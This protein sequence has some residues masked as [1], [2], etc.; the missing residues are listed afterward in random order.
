MRIFG[1]GPTTCLVALVALIGAILLRSQPLGASQRLAIRPDDGVAI[2][3]TWYE[4]PSRPAP[5]VILVHMLQK[6]RRDWDQFA[7]RLASEGIG[8]L[9]I[10]LRGHGES[11]GSAQDFAG[12]VQDIRAARRYLSARSE[13][14]P[15]RI[16]IAGASIG[17]TLAAQ[18]AADDPAIASLVL[19]SPT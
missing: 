16:G 12:M 9:A 10:D 17:A 18:A 13:V 8:A 11:Q 2:A 14:T 15:S 3:A 1:G 5:A 19:L 7:T 4:P 6:S